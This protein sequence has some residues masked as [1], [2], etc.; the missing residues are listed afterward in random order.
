MSSPWLSKVNPDC[1]YSPSFYVSVLLAGEEVNEGT[2]FLKERGPVI[3]T[4]LHEEVLL[5][6]TYQND[7]VSCGKSHNVSTGH[8]LGAGLFKQCFGL[9][10]DL[11]ASHGQVRRGHFLRIRIACSR[12]QQYR[13]I[14]SLHPLMREEFQRRVSCDCGYLQ[15]RDMYGNGHTHTM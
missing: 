11:V 13:T 8:N 7:R 4:T 1:T 3:T 6:G 9:I 10:D 14:A 15:T 5:I 2:E 12:V